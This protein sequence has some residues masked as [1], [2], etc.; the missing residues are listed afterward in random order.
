MIMKRLLLAS[1][2]GSVLFM[3]QSASATVTR[4]E[5]LQSNGGV[6]DEALIYSYPGM[7]GKYN[8]ALAEIGKFNAGAYT[9]A[10]AAAF[11]TLQSI[12]LGASVSRSEWLFTN[13]LIA[14]RD[15]SLFDRY[16]AKVID[17]ANN[18]PF[19]VVPEKP[20]EVFAGFSLAGGTLGF[21]LAFASRSDTAEDVTLNVASKTARSAQEIQFSTGFHTDA[22]GSLDI[23]FTMDP[24]SSQ[25]YSKD[26]GSSSSE[27]SIK[28]GGATKLAGRWIQ[29]GTTGGIYANG[30]IL[31][32]S[33]KLS[34]T[35]GGTDYSSKFTDQVITLEGGYAAVK[36]ATGPKLFA[37]ADVVRFSSK[38]PT[39]LTGSGGTSEPSYTKN[40]EA[41][42]ISGTISSATLS[43]EASVTSGVGLMAGMKY[44]LYGNITETDNTAD[45]HKKTVDSVDETSDAALWSIGMYYQADALRVDAVVK[46]DFLYNGPNF[47]SGNTTAPLFAKIGAHYMF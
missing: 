37:G 42:K 43:G 33:A 15:I 9:H 21:K 13:L 1:L 41:A 4:Q 3:A 24:S 20:I 35:S 30:S 32:R 26:S 2:S 12:S 46:K 19:L 31:T 27:I 39:I 40:G 34:A 5:A 14:D 7:I 23:A 8:L 45:L 38:G 10:H 44:V 47:I 22:A 18:G 16:E 29:S 11:T 36:T 6:E 28:G 25:K 17:T